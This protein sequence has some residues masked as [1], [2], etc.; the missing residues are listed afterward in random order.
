MFIDFS[1][2]QS[3]SALQER[4]SNGETLIESWVVNWNPGF[5][6]CLENMAKSPN[7]VTLIQRV[8]SPTG[9]CYMQRLSQ[10]PFDC[11]VRRPIQLY[12]PIFSQR[13]STQHRSASARSRAY[14]RSLKMWST[15]VD[16]TYWVH[17]LPFHYGCRR[18]CFLSTQ[19][20]WSVRWTPRSISSY[21]LFSRWANFGKWRRTTPTSWSTSF[22]NTNKVKVHPKM[23]SLARRL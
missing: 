3:I 12:D 9:S 11:I 19:L 23:S 5:N 6:I 20:P 10:R 4:S 18:D 22:G 2:V 8:R 13:P 1:S 17:H 21:Q 16:W 15:L 14:E 7:F